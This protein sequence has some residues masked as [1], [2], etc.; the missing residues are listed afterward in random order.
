VKTLVLAVTLAASATAHADA[1]RASYV[2]RALAAVHALG[3]DGRARLERDV[4]E[5]TRARC[6]TDVAPAT[7]ACSIDA[8]RAAC[9]GAADHDACA[10]AADVV[11]EDLRAAG[12]LVD[13]ATRARLV[14]TSSD[15][16]AA[17]AAELHRRYALLA[18][19][20]ALDPAAGRDPAGAIDRL[21]ARRDERVH[22]CAPGDAACIPSLAWP[23][24]VAALI[25]YV[26]GDGGAP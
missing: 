23:R 8:A 10:L 13:D 16:R 20:L 22:A 19:E 6:H 15:Y 25:G 4:Y 26:G 7:V 5:A 11:A 2:A 3:A 14:R 9:D 21:C 1:S 18:A 17:L 12:D 24:C